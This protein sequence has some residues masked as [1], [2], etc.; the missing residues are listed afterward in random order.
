MDVVLLHNENAGDED[1]SRKALVKLVRSAGLR[2]KYFELDDALDDPRVLDRG[3]FVIAAGGDGSIR[4]VALALYGREIPLAPLPL[5]T[6]N[7]IARSLGLSLAPEEVVAGW[8]KYRRRSFDVGAVT[9]PWGKR[10]FVE[11][12]GLG[13]ISR[14]ICTLDEI[15]NSGAPELK[16]ARH[17]LV[18]DACVAT[19]LA[20]EMTP[21]PARLEIGGRTTEH[22]YLLLEVLN[23]GRAGPTFELTDA[24]SCDGRFDVV[25]VTAAQR[26]R[27]MRALMDR[28]SESERPRTLP[29]RGAKSVRITP[30]ETCDLRIDDGAKRL[31]GGVSVEISMEPEALEVIVPG[32]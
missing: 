29:S 32:R 12:V 23:I 1:W 21:V 26:P 6:A 13:L 17:R 10:L 2:P 19:A 18:R 5:G 27:L 9:G 25:H 22:D 7:N 16:K 31:R 20:R 8:K 28:L 24:N 3:E 14:T 4:K 11:G 15:D 30:R